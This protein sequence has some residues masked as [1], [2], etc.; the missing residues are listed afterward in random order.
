M[1][2]HTRGAASQHTLSR[3]PPCVCVCATQCPRQ[4]ANSV[5]NTYPVVQSVQS[6]MT[7][8]TVRP[9]VVGVL[10]TLHGAVILMTP[11]KPTNGMCHRGSVVC[12][13][14]RARVCVKNRRVRGMQKANLQGGLS[15]DAPKMTADHST[16]VTNL[17]WCSVRLCAQQRAELQRLRWWRLDALHNLAFCRARSHKT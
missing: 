10:G 17:S 4:R 2:L 14:A 12:A 7:V 9:R 1:R 8:S 13:C 5:N 11:P 3:L 16:H 15:K 6:T